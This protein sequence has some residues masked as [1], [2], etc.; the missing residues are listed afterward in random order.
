M[1]IV[2]S[3]QHVG[4]GNQAIKFIINYFKDMQIE[5]IILEVRMDNIPALK[6]YKKVGF[7]IVED[8]KNFYNDGADGYRMS[9]SLNV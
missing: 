8:V 7:E 3:Y 1:S 4:I 2:P 9:K 5:K 6:L